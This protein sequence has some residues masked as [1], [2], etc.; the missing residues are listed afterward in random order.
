MPQSIEP[1]RGIGSQAFEHDQSPGGLC[2]V[3]AL[4]KNH[5]EL[6][7]WEG[8]GRFELEGFFEMSFRFL[9]LAC[10]NGQSTSQLLKLRR[11]SGR[12]VETFERLSGSAELALPDSEVCQEKAISGGGGVNFN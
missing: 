6:E 8:I 4:H 12:R 10:G 7:G 3:I 5:G 9:K 2:G 1:N 11:F